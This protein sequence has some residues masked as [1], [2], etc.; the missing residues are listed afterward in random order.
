MNKKQATLLSAL[1]LTICLPAHAV[2]LRYKFAKDETL[3][4]RLMIAGA[5][6]VTGIGGP[7]INV[8]FTADGVVSQKVLD[9]D[10]QGVARVELQPL[11]GSMKMKIGENEQTLPFPVGKSV[12]KVTTRGKVTPIKGGASGQEG[13][14]QM[15]GPG[16]DVSDIAGAVQLPEGDVKVGESWQGTTKLTVQGLGE[17]AIKYSGTL[18]GFK[19]V[20]GANCAVVKETFEAPIQLDAATAKMPMT[21]SGKIAGTLQIHLDNEHG[22]DVYSSAEMLYLQKGSMTMGE[23]TIEMTQSMKMNLRQYLL[24]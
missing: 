16:F 22:Y 24:Q 11:K 7:S 15:A 3:R 1:L 9:V 21:G 6:Q 19:K 18:V 4:Y 10:A 5:S 12:M 14:P 23:Q 13:A 17:I 2:R 20:K 8:Q